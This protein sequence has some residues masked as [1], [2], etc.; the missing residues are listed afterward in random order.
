[1]THQTNNISSSLVQHKAENSCHNQK[2]VFE[3]GA[4]ARTLPTPPRADDQ[5]YNRGKTN[6][7]IKGQRRDVYL[8]EICL[9]KYN[10]EI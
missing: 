3:V 1:M 4:A 2:F 8:K 9:Y 5:P 7:F 10:S 6:H